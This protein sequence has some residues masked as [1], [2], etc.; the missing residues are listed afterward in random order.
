MLTVCMLFIILC[1]GMALLYK[2]RSTM[3]AMKSNSHGHGHGHGPPYGYKYEQATVVNHPHHH[4]GSAHHP[5]FDMGNGD[6]F[7]ILSFLFWLK[8]SLNFFLYKTRLAI[9]FSKRT[10]WFLKRFF[11]CLL[12]F[13]SYIANCCNFLLDNLESVLVRIKVGYLVKMS[14]CQNGP[15]PS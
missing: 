4:M 8:V 5:H 7:S 12:K 15:L 3:A 2:R 1:V 11:V 14:P 9:I 10:K 13:V 6:F